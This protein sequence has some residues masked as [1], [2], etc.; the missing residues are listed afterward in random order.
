LQDAVLDHVHVRGVVR[1]GVDD[2]LDATL[3][4]HAQVLVVEVEAV[5][6]SAWM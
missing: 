2:D 1:V 5:G 4:G 3:F 6:I